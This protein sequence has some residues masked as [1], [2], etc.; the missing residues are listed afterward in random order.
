MTLVKSLY[1]G[2]PDVIRN[3]RTYKVPDVH[4]GFSTCKG[5]SAYFPDKSMCLA[6]ALGRPCRGPNVV[7]GNGQVDAPNSQLI[8][9]L[10]SSLGSG[11]LRCRGAE[12]GAP[13]VTCLSG[14]AL[15]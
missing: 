7:V 14:M 10:D 1:S 4:S 8:S 6:H 12:V 15:S 13:P 9:C 3:T 2:D 5:Y 11:R